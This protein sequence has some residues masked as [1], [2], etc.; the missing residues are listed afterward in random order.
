M[1]RCSLLKYTS[2]TVEEDRLFVVF[3][4]GKNIHAGAN[5]QRIKR[6]PAANGPRN[7]E[8]ILRNDNHGGAKSRDEYEAE[9]I[10]R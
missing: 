6:K 1:K 3:N 10:R 5:V 9:A 4:F 2:A 8:C 7:K